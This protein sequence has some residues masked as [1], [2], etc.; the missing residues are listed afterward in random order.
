MR[1]N[2]EVN[3]KEGKKVLK[4]F[5]A[6][7]INK[8]ECIRSLFSLGYEVKEISKEMNIIY[9][10]VY[11][12]VSKMILRNDMENEI[13]KDKKVN[14]IDEL[15]EFVNSN[16]GIKKSEVVKHFVKAGRGEGYVYNSIKKAVADNKI[17]FE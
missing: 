6:G 2:V 8:S 15:I 3:Q 13:I 9:N 12:I 10:M 5:E 16:A 1:L 14:F 4:A 11:N 7:K 17:K